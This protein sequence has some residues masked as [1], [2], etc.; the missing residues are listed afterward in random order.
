MVERIFNDPLAWGILAGFAVLAFVISM[1][2]KSEFDGDS[3]SSVVSDK[4]ASN[5]SIK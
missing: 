5:M 1:I 3:S 4:Y 2:F